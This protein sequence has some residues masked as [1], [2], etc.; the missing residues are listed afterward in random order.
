VVSIY[1][2]EIEGYQQE[3]VPN[4]FFQANEEASE[5]LAFLLPGGGYPC[6][7]PVL[8]YP[9][10]ELL[11]RGIDV[12]AVDYTRRPQISAYSLEQATAC[13]FTD[14]VAAYETIKSKHAYKQL[15]LVGKSL[16]TLVMGKLLA[17]HS[18]FAPSQ[19]AWLTPVLSSAVL[20]EQ[21]CRDP[22]PSLFVIGTADEFYDAEHLAEVQQATNGEVVV[23]PQAD[24]SL[25][26][27]TDARRSL[28]AIERMREAMHA[29]LER[30][31]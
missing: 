29:F 11:D 3:P 12:L 14:T 23:I 9:L 15:T 4:F 18:L 31:R 10:L 7:G 17:S 13:A 24:H 26:I 1:P 16:G 21:I 2:L 20:R 27:G 8:Y 30:S 25:D 6:A 22:I 5:H 28:Q 19:A